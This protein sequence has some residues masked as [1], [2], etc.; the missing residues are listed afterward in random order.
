SIHPD[1]LML[2]LLFGITMFLSQKIMMSLNKTKNMDPAQEAMQKSMGT[3][4]PIMIMATFIFIPIP[5]G[6]FL[7]L[8]TSNVI[9]IFQTIIV[10][11]Q[12]E[13]EE[14][15]RKARIDDDIVKNAKTVKIKE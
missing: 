6:V 11:K 1:V 13:M 9:Q 5:A 10:D 15:K 3:F 7:Y 14:A 4:M 2:I 8:I 12:L